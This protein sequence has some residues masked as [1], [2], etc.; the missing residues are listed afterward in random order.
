MPAYQEGQQIERTRADGHR[1]QDAVFVG[2]E[3]TAGPVVEAKTFE[4]ENLVRRKCVHAPFLP[5]RE[6]GQPRRGFYAV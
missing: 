1:D 2:S 4:Y 3:Q 5:N 6:R